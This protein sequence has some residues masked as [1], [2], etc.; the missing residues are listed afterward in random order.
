MRIGRALGA[1]AVMAALWMAIGASS[2]SAAAVVRTIAVGDLPDAVASDGTD[3]WVAHNAA[4]GTVSEIAASTGTVVKTITVGGDYSAGVSSDGTHVWVANPVSEGADGATGTVSEIA[5]STGTVVKTIPVGTYPEAVSSDGTHVWVPNL[6][7]GTVSEL[8]ASTGTVV[9]TI[10]VGSDPSAVS[11][12]GSHVW[13][14]NAG[15]GTVSE[16]S[17]STGTV[18]KAI[19]VGTRPAGVSSDG[20]HVWVT[21]FGD[22]TSTCC[23][24]SEIDAS[25]GTVVKTIRV[26]SEPDG[27]SSDGTHVWVANASDGTVSEIDA[28][29]GSVVNTLTVGSLPEGMSSDGTH[30]WVGNAE[31]GTVSEIEIGTT[32]SPTINGPRNPSELPTGCSCGDP[33]DTATGEFW[34]TFTD[35]AVPGLG[36]RLNFTRTYDSAG[37]STSASLGHGWTDSYNMHLSFD[38]SGNATVGQENGTRVLFHK[39]A[40]NYVAATGVLASLVASTGGTYTFTRDATNDR[41]VFN[42]SGRLIREVDRNGYT[43]KL[44]YNAIGDLTQVTDQTG[45]SLTFAYGGGQLVSV[46][47]PLGHKTS[48]TYDATGDLTRVIDPLGRIWAFTYDAKH[49][50]VSI[51]D[52]HGGKTTNTYDS[53][54]RVTKQL[55]P[56]GR[57]TTFSYNGDPTS[58]TGGTTTLTDPRGVET[59]YE[60]SQLELTSMKA[61]VGTPE[62]ATTSYQY[63]PTTFGRTKI[64]DPNGKVTTNTYDARGDLLTTTDPLGEVTKFT[65]DAEGDRLTATDPLGTKTSYT[66]DANG[67][68]LAS[69][70]PL[71]GGG[72][73]KRS[74]TYGTGATAGDVLTS[75]N[76]DGMT[77]TFGYDLAGDAT[78]TT[79]PLGKRTTATYDSDGRLLTQTTPDGHTTT[80]AYDADGELTKTTDALGQSTSYGYDQNGNQISLN[81]ANGHTTTYGYDADNEQTRVTRPDGTTTTTTYDGDGNVLT[82]TDGNEH[83]TSYTYDPLNR[84]ATTTDPDGHKTTDTHDGDGNLRSSVDP[85]GATT[86]YTYDADNRLAGI[87]YSDRTTPNVTETYDADGDRTSLRGGTGTSTFTYDTL[88]SVTSQ[89]NGAGAATSY[90][91]DAAGHMTSVTYPNGQTVKRSYDGDGDL[92]SVKDWLGNTTTFG[93]D[94]DRNLTRETFPASAG[95][96]D[97]STYDRADRLSA[98]TDKRGSSTL[99]AASYARDSTGQLLS[100]SSAPAVTHSYRYTSLNQ[101]CYAGSTNTTACASPPTGAVPYRYDAADNLVQTE[102]TTQSFNPANQLCWTARPPS[103]AACGSPPA[104]A[105]KY[106]YDPRGNRTAITPATGTATTLSYDQANRLTRYTHGT[107]AASYTYNGDGRRM[108]KTVNG[109]TTKFAWD[110]SGGLPLLLQ[111]GSTYYIYGPSGQPIEQI[112]GSTPIYLLADQQGSTRLLTNDTG[113]VVGTYSYDPWGN[114][115][116]HTGIAT[117]N[118][119]Y[120]GQYTDPE[121]R[122]LYLRARYYDPGTGQ[123]L[124]QDPVEATTREPYGYAIDNPVNADDPTGMGM[125]VRGFKALLTSN[126]AKE[127]AV[128]GY[129][130]LLLGPSINYA[131]EQGPGPELF[132]GLARTAKALDDVGSAWTEG[133]LGVVSRLVALDLGEAAQA[134]NGFGASPSVS[135]SFNYVASYATLAASQLQLLANGDAREAISQAGE[136]VGEVVHA[137][138]MLNQ[139]NPSTRVGDGLSCSP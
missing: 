58:A 43:T 64:T 121:S 115:T 29:T 37:A 13:V 44:T 60:S 86:T 47:D 80:K 41:Y 65:Y 98:V 27:V 117:T 84:M 23:T 12:D 110:E 102:Q 78:S 139:D 67:N 50:L 137:V 57:T 128:D 42:G 48:Y 107:T 14:T 105:T 127:E 116:S 74:S 79:D 39:T 109:A 106:T 71:S 131:A 24:V 2:A 85:S 15:G 114:F 63:D 132:A 62:A 134:A 61:G 72:T 122:F 77:T 69:S 54:H 19:T 68:V 76:P 66:Y 130:D 53:S 6:L 124:T 17:A 119:Q 90:A 112:T 34:R 7:D 46:A 135:N 28:S 75:T 138:G 22:E 26:G 33:V 38:A 4:P 89:T 101:L 133:T 87:E 136:G 81:D 51:T 3:A 9:K 11:S 129:A 21:N 123:F 55:D 10:R 99:F 40:P 31:D 111:A 126:G 5:A 104:G 88:R 91:Y 52:P 16:I 83:T 73:A 59:Q 45:R 96:V 20:T 93:Y 95:V 8:A 35:V 82:Q 125:I 18:V 94:A 118:V 103:S 120:D 56:A 49:L 92:S 25:T 100:D 30:A 108:S 113:N 36:V 1:L 32:P 70:A 97:T